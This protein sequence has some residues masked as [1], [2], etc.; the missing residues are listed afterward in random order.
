MALESRD[1]PEILGL[2]AVKPDD[3]QAAG[4][5]QLAEVDIPCRARPCVHH[6]LTVVAAA[7]AM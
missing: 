6:T 7:L 1:N 5:E 3:Q 4:R 2:A